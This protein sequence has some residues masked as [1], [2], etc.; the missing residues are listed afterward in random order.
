MVE[1]NFNNNEHEDI[2]INFKQIIN[3]LIYRKNL[4]F[5]LSILIIPLFLGFY[6]ISPKK[7]ETN[8]KL[9]VNSSVNTNLMDINPYIIGN[10]GGGTS[11]GSL[12]SMLSGLG[13]SL[14]N[15]IEIIKSPLVI[16]QVIKENNLKYKKGPKTGKYINTHD[17]LN[18]NLSITSDGKGSNIL[19]ISYKAKEPEF[20]YNIVTSIINNYKKTKRLMNIDKT[21]KDIDFLNK[22][23]QKIEKGL[24][25]QI[26][27]L[28][29]SDA[30]LYN[31]MSGAQSINIVE[32]YY[33]KNIKNLLDKMA[34]K[35]LDSKKLYLEMERNIEKLKM[36]QSKLD[37]SN[38]VQKM[39]ENTSNIIVL[40]PPVKKENFEYSEPKLIT[41]LILGF[42]LA[43]FTSIISIII[44]EVRD[45]KL[46]YSSFDENTVSNED[47]LDQLI[48]NLSVKDERA[49]LLAPKTTNNESVQQLASSQNVSLTNIETM[50]NIIT[51][52]KGANSVILAGE[53]GETPKKTYK[54]I[55]QTC[56]ELD[57]NIISEV[58][59][60]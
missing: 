23:Y 28:K 7:Y 58:I 29:A 40:E 22:E 3:I 60:K 16:D 44:A 42:I 35:S 45:K 52:I 11:S 1:N 12:S 26:D 56:K 25:S 47:E 30:K 31:A 51:S 32:S 49:T 2:T 36:I 20:A 39:A 59:I 24:N 48:I 15:E 54:L 50:E 8:A 57:K 10:A 38:L 5:I 9:Y 33:D 37:W 4:F 55:K 14:K 53:I 17:F 27:I 18:K 6:F 43:I 46:T 13:G 21:E 34:D 19:S 41:H